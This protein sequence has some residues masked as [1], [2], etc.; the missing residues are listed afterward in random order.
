MGAHDVTKRFYIS[1]SAADGTVTISRTA[2]RNLGGGNVVK[3]P[4]CLFNRRA[5]ADNS[6]SNQVCI[7][8][9]IDSV[10]DFKTI[11]ISPC[12]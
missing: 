1:V 5:L 3:V 12:S 6:N 10:G 2:K 7:W 11:W 8:E 4:I 9:A